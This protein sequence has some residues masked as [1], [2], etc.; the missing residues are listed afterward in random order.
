[1]KKRMAELLASGSAS[2]KG[3]SSPFG[4]SGGSRLFASLFF[5]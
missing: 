3:A 5:A 1:M 2:A 4:G